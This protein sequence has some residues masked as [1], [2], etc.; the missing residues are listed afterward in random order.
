MIQLLLKVY[1]ILHGAHPYSVLPVGW[2]NA[3]FH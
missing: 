3:I 1:C 2:L